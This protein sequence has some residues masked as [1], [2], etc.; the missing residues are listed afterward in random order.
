MNQHLIETEKKRILG[1]WGQ[2][3][4]EVSCEKALEACLPVMDQ[5]CGRHRS[6]SE[7]MSALYQSFTG[8]YF[9]DSRK[10][11]EGEDLEPAKRFFLDV[12]GE[13][14]NREKERLPFDRCRDFEYLS[15]E[16]VQKSEIREEYCQYIRQFRE[17]EI[18]PFLRIARECTPFDT[19]GHIAGVH[20]TAMHVA[21]QLKNTPVPVDLALISAAA[22]IHDIGKFGCRGKEAGR[23]PYLHYYYTAQF[24]KRFHF[25]TIGHIAANHST[26]DLELENLSVENLILIYADFRVKSMRGADGKEQ[27][28]FWTL[29]E[30]YQVILDKLDN[31]DDRKRARYRKVFRK[32]KDFEEFLKALG[33]SPDL[34]QGFGR[35]EKEKSASLLDMHEIAGRIKYSAI[36]SNIVVMHNMI[37]KYRFVS[38]L[39]EA[40][41]EKDWRNVRSYLNILDEYSTYMTCSQKDASIRFLYE[42]MMHRDGDIRR[43]A[44]RITGELIADYEVHYQKEVPEGATELEE[45][46]SAEEKWEEV[47]RAAVIPDHKIS[48]QHKRWLGYAM[49]TVFSTV[50]DQISE[51]KRPRV[52]QALLKYYTKKDWEDLVMFVLMDCA[53]GFSFAMFEE[54]QVKVLIDFAKSALSRKNPELHTAALRFLELW[55][56]QG[57]KPERQE[58]ERLETCL[59]SGEALPVCCRYL[60]GKLRRCLDGAENAENLLET[61]NRTVSSLFLE[62]QQ[63]DTPWIFKMVNLEILKEHCLQNQKEMFQL[64]AHLVN[65]L[66]NTDRIV[67]KH[68]SGNELTGLILHLSD[69]EKYEIAMELVRGLEIGEYSISKYIPEYLGKIFFCLSDETQREMLELFRKMIDSTNPKAAIVTLETVGIMLQ[70]F[71]AYSQRT[72]EKKEFY[73]WCREVLEGLLFRGMAHYLEGV[74]QEAFY[75]IGHNIFGSRQ[76]DMDQK[77]SFFQTTGRKLL[78]L[79]G[80]EKDHVRLYNHAAALN[81]IYRFLSD[82]LFLHGRI[83]EEHVEKIAFFPG[84]FD[85]FSLGHKEIVK[86]IRRRGFRVYL[87]LDEFSWSKKTQPYKIRETIVKMSAADLREVYLFPEEIPVN[88]SNCRDLR[89][90]RACFPGKEVYLVAGSDVVEHASAY[91][92]PV[93]EDSV[94]HFPHLIF[95]RRT[96]PAKEQLRRELE[97]TLAGEKVYWLSL[98]KGFEEIS[99]TK[100]REHIDRNRDISNLVDQNVQ[101]YIYD[102][103]LYTREPMF[104]FMTASIPVDAYYEEHIEPELKK[105]LVMGLLKE[106]W[107]YGRNPAAACL[108]REEAVLIRDGQQYRQVIG[109]V[110]FH[111]LSFAELYGECGSIETAAYLRNQISGKTAVITG[112]YGRDTGEAAD[113]RQAVL[114]EMLV[115]CAGLGYTY[116]ICFGKTELEEL[117][118]AQGFVRLPLK[119]ACYLV[120]LRNPIV[121]FGDACMSLKEPFRSSRVMKEEIWKR[122]KSLQKAFTGLFPGNL[123]LCIDSGILN[124]RLIQRITEE[125]QVPMI[126]MPRRILGEKMCV[127]FGRILRGTL[128]PNCVTKELDAEKIYFPDMERFAIREYPNGAALDI[129]IRTIKSFQRPV[130]LVDDLFH[131]G[132][133]MERIDPALEREGVEVGKIIVGVLS[134]KGKDLADQRG[135]KIDCVYFLPNMRAWFMESVLYPFIGGDSIM[136]ENERTMQTMLLPSVNSILPYQVPGFLEGISAAG[137]YQLSE[138]CLE[139]AE[140]ILRLLEKEY[141]RL[142][143]RKLTVRRLGEVMAQPRCPELGMEALETSGEAPSSYLKLEKNRLKRLKYISGLSV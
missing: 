112:I 62:N 124:H 72:P 127:P 119:E 26:W 74:S 55:A 88:I 108:E 7:W 93:Q 3:S 4:A 87:A 125:N 28:C 120:D 29:D 15:D 36:R 64:A 52:M 129:Q 11:D 143:G 10:Q 130:I 69:A 44:A 90:L 121:L 16:E 117:L 56:E 89:R 83:P 107:D 48:E 99:S 73:E 110:L 9:P 131:K 67:I 70:Y 94:H 139:N 20:F 2:P 122:R 31:V 114:T 19:L 101:N 92:N 116:G 65:M 50:M 115:R 61:E 41:S 76:L 46:V 79:M 135:K 22:M 78:T 35:P 104:K 43:Q 47:L 38:L 71:F 95:L 32:L 97:G 40:K 12:L 98:P 54:Q 132:Y 13:L 21:R 137:Y 30:S 138:L 6:A 109:I 75:I 80:K 8:I 42:M 59:I 51:E 5:L 45:G 17:L 34:E 24:S 118:L 84:T 96:D 91:R 39:E 141:Q 142:T 134:G 37:Q 111:R 60:I 102:M 81:H 105:E 27:I 123:V 68:H 103:G 63:I 77:Y 86:E 100:I 136:R 82:Y 23:V 18:Y 53:G 1:S 85:P 133:R 128:V 25:E 113:S 106:F 66:Q 126:Q 49:K 58:R 57:W 14:L 33:V 140:A